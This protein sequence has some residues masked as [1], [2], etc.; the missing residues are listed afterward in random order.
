[1]RK[2]AVAERDDLDQHVLRARG[3]PM[4]AALRGDDDDAAGAET[5]LGRRIDPVAVAPGERAR[6]DRQQA[7][8]AALAMRRQH[9]S[10][11]NA[12]QEDAGPALAVH[13]ND[14]ALGDVMHGLVAELV[15]V[16]RGGLAGHGTMAPERD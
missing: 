2:G 16:Q 8:A 4:H 3:G 14:A 5:A 12:E 9:L 15:D 7:D 13:G 6:E 11:G 10:P 1:R